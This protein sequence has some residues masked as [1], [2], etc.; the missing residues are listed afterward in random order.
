MKIGGR[1]LWIPVGLSIS[2][3]TI[4]VAF[5]KYRCLSGALGGR[6]FSS[7]EEAER[8]LRTVSAGA[9]SNDFSVSYEK[10]PE[11]KNP[12]AGK[13]PSSSNGLDI[14]PPAPTT[15]PDS[16]FVNLGL[17]KIVSWDLKRSGETVDYDR[18]VGL[19]S[20]ADV[21]IIYNIDLDEKGKG[22]LHILGDLVQG[23]LKEKICRM[24]F[25]S[26]NNSW[27]TSISPVK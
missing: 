9:S 13:N 11:A 16:V 10:S 27:L 26:A 24:W 6:E 5:N 14:L 1:S 17:L 22:P 12:T 2:M 4:A 25:R 8:S 7:K 18:I 3:F 19:L 20:E 23:R 15:A 21:S